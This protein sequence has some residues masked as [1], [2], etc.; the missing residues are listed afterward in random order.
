MIRITE[1]LINEVSEKAKTSARKRTNYNFHKS[2]NDPVQ[3]FLNAVEPDS[4]LQ[5]HKHQ[6]PDKT[7]IFLILRGRVLIVEFDEIGKI[8]EH[9]ILGSE[10]G[11]LAVEIPARTWHSFIALE[12][13]S[14]LYEIKEG[15]FIQETGKTS[16]SWAP[17]EGTREA[18]EFNK[19][20]LEE[21]N[22]ETK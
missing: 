14:V 3:R 9:L 18:V 4:Y 12:E 19:K 11:N 15:P 10:V 17:E 8:T 13:G 16:A 21:L 20:I 1:E 5:P 6:D 7:E 22:L 2:Y